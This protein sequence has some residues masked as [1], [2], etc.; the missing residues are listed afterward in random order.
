MGGGPGELPRIWSGFRLAG[1]VLGRSARATVP[2][3]TGHLPAV[4]PPLVGLGRFSADRRGPE[5]WWPQS[6]H[7]PLTCNQA[8]AFGQRYC[9]RLPSVAVLGLGQ[10]PDVLTF[11]W[12]LFH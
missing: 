12:G 10:A 4:M 6:A 2:G 5:C 8:P 3:K 11:S 7:L 1:T 9:G